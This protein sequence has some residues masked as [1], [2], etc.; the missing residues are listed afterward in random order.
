M[1]LREQRALARTCQPCSRMSGTSIRPTSLPRLMWV[2]G[3][4]TW[5]CGNAGNSWSATRCPSGLL[6]RLANDPSIAC[7]ALAHD[8]HPDAR[9][10]RRR[11][12]GQL[13]AKAGVHHVF[14][15]MEAPWEEEALVVGRRGGWARTY[16]QRKGH[17]AVSAWEFWCGRRGGV[18]H[19]RAWKAPADALCV[20]L[21]LRGLS[22]PSGKG[23]SEHCGV[24]QVVEVPNPSE[25]LG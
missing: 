19:R 1:T 8:P 2:C 16:R 5:V 4:Q 3:V 25:F 13:I 9:R 18:S 6:F 14:P 12:G 23:R 10:T 22:S 15:A 11:S 20:A 21:A 17:S 7:R 24:P